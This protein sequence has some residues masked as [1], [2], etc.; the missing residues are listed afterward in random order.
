[1][2]PLRG[3]AQLVAGAATY[4][5]AFDVSAFCYAETALAPLVADEIVSQIASATASM[6]VLR[7]VTWAALQRHHPEVHLA[8]AGE[9]MSDAGMPAVRKALADGL[10]AAF[11]LATEGG[12]DANPRSGAGGT[13]SS[14]SASGAK[15]GSRRT[16]SGT[17]ARA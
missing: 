11:G 1:M 15:Q 14:S 5:L 4:R 17:K 13:G 12:D 9:I 7:G 2:N 3:E 6:T 8:Q 16:S 10:Q